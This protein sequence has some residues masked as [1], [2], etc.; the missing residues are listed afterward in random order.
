VRNKFKGEIELTIR[1]IDDNSIVSSETIYNVCTDVLDLLVYNPKHSSLSIGLSNE[2]YN[3]STGAGVG[4]VFVHTSPLPFTNGKT[5]ITKPLDGSTALNYASLYGRTSN[6]EYVDTIQRKVG[7]LTIKSIGLYGVVAPQ[8]S[9]TRNIKNVLYAYRTLTNAVEV[10]SSQIVD[11][12]YRIYLPVS[13]TGANISESLAEAL[14][15]TLWKQGTTSLLS[16]TLTPFYWED[17]TTLRY[18]GNVF[19]NVCSINSIQ[20]SAISKVSLSLL[21]NV[22]T[23]GIG[24][25]FRTSAVNMK[26]NSAYV[27]MMSNPLHTTG[28]E[29]VSCI[30]AK[31]NTSLTPFTARPESIWMD[32]TSMVGTVT[33]IV[34]EAA[35]DAS[36]GLDQLPRIVRLI[37]TNPSGNYKYHFKTRPFISFNGNTYKEDPITLGFTNNYLTAFSE[38]VVDQSTIPSFTIGTPS[39]ALRT[40]LTD[41]VVQK[42]SNKY[43]ISLNQNEFAIH[44]VIKND[45]Y[46]VNMYT[47]NTDVTHSFANISKQRTVDTVNILSNKIECTSH[48]YSNGDTLW[49]DSDDTMPGGISKRT[50]YYV[51]NAT[52]ND[53]QIS[54][55]SGGTAVTITSEGAGTITFQA[56]HSFV[57]ATEMFTATIVN[58][59]ISTPTEMFLIA[60]KSTTVGGLYAVI[61]DD[62]TS[63]KIVPITTGGSPASFP[64]D[65]VRPIHGVYITVD[66]SIPTSPYSPSRSIWVAYRDGLTTDGGFLVTADVDSSPALD[67]SDELTWDSTTYTTVTVSNNVKTSLGGTTPTRTWANLHSIKVSPNQNYVAFLN[68]NTAQIT[69]GDNYYNHRTYS[70]NT[71]TSAVTMAGSKCTTGVVG[72]Y[73]ITN[74]YVLS[75]TDFAG[76][77]GSVKRMTHGTSTIT[78]TASIGTDSNLVLLRGETEDYVLNRTGYVKVSDLTVSSFATVNGNWS[79]TGTSMCKTAYL[80]N[81]LIFTMTSTSTLLSVIPNPNTASSNHGATGATL[82]E[83]VFEEFVWTTYA[84]DGSD[85]YV[86]S[87]NEPATANKKFLSA[88]SHDLIDGI[89]VTFDQFGT[90]PTNYLATGGRYYDIYVCPGVIRDDLTDISIE[91]PVYNFTTEYV[92][93]FSDEYAVAISQV[94]L[95]GNMKFHDKTVGSRMT[96]QNSLSSGYQIAGAYGNSVSGAIEPNVVISDV[97]FPATTTATNYGVA[98]TVNA[99]SITATGHHFEEGDPVYFTSTDI[100]VETGL[101]AGTVYYAKNV[102]SSPMTLSATANGPALS[103]SASTVSGS[104]L[105]GLYQTLKFKTVSPV[106]NIIPMTGIATAAIATLNVAVTA[107]NKWTMTG[108]VV[109]ASSTD[110]YDL[111]NDIIFVRRNTLTNKLEAGVIQSSGVPQ[112]LAYTT[113]TAGTVT[114]ELFISVFNSCGVYDQTLKLPMFR[115]PVVHVGNEA[116]SQGVFDPL[117]RSVEDLTASTERETTNGPTISF[118]TLPHTI[119]LDGNTLTTSSINRRC[120]TLPTAANTVS[121]AS[122]SGL[123]IFHP[124]NEGDSLTVNILCLKK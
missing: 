22:N 3:P 111:D 109:N 39:A 80:G 20:G 66:T 75:T 31:K 60:D 18:K 85:W 1:N 61:I 62:V 124:N 84:Y 102:A 99:N 17:A 79:S 100:N 35:Y 88:P 11:I 15:P 86:T 78:S 115:Y 40:S 72:S 106:I 54:T 6:S 68:A 13:Y 64:N 10:S 32:G 46:P 87:L 28:A 19:G 123:L 105:R 83:G 43:A 94:P 34:D 9:D 33:P 116:F 48:D 121:I 101:V 38:D 25:A 67:L 93:T 63:I 118:T 77:I 56:T 4:G 91:Q 55:S 21:A 52:A 5:W 41:V 120:L 57:Q 53:F 104:V 108:W 24:Q 81:G 74:S 8:T 14:F 44:D 47:T 82:A 98:C 122:G 45:V 37:V 95:S 96:I 92:D 36:Y 69:A 29:L 2:S 76:D 30:Y 16:A 107:S 27:P 114:S 51:I 71:S 12:R 113:G 110:D 103:Y 117:F 65:G 119:V 42:I 23:T 89:S 50:T 58:E 70:F 90:T 73:D 112:M 7:P 49:F 59:G 97:P 26:Y